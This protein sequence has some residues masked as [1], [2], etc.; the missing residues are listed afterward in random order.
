MASSLIGQLRILLG[1]ETASLEAGAAKAKAELRG[2]AESAEFVKHTLERIG[3][4]FAAAE[5]YEF[6]KGALEYAASL[7]TT[8]N[9]VGVTVEQLQVMRKAAREYGVE[10]AVM[11]TGLAKLNITLGKAKGGAAGAVKAFAGLGIKPEQLAS[12]HQAGDALPAVE[13]GL[14][15]VGDKATQGAAAWG[16]IGKGAAAALPVFTM[17]KE[18][19]DELTAAAVE[20][21][22]ITTDQAHRAHEAEVAVGELAVALKSRLAIAIADNVEE[23][24]GFITELEHMLGKIGQMMDML[25]S[26]RFKAS[27]AQISFNDL[28]D[29]ARAGM[30]WMGM[31]GG[32]DPGEYQGRHQGNQAQFAEMDASELRAYQRRH[33]PALFNGG[34]KEPTAPPPNHLD[35]SHHKKPKKHADHTEQREKEAERIK[36]DLDK[37]ELDG[38]KQLLE[39]QK[40]LAASTEDRDAIQLQ[41]LQ[42][43]HD[44]KALEIAHKLK[45][46]ELDRTVSPVQ[47]KAAELEAKSANA[48]NDR[49]LILNKANLGLQQ[50]LEQEREAEAYDQ[51]ILKSHT[52]RLKLEEDLV[53]TTAERRTIEL[54]LLRLAY[55]Q[56]ARQLKAII[57][58]TYVY[59]DDNGKSQTIYTHSAAERDQARVELYG[60]H[61][62][63]NNTARS[64]A[65]NYELERQKVLRS[66][67]GPLEQ[68][69][70]SIPDTAKRMN[71][72]L[73]E[74]AA[75]G[76]K[77]M[78]DGLAEASASWI[79]LGGTAG[80]ILRQIY[81]DIMKILIMKFIEK[82][83]INAL[84]GLFGGAGGG[85]L[86]SFAN[87][88]DDAAF[89]PGF[90]T[91]G[92][93]IIGG[94]GGVDRNLLS[95][96]GSPVARVNQGERLDIV[97][98]NDRGEGGGATIYN[99]MRGAVLTQDLYDH[100]NRVGV[101][102]AMTGGAL[103]Q[104][105]AVTTL[106]RRAARML[107]TGRR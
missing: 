73:E 31:A 27:K 53:K 71:E 47:K 4:G 21:G 52:D 65:Q 101:Q 7:S 13:E 66:T 50:R 95:I 15:N 89:L 43:D 63:G 74:V 3:I 56:R 90:A 17:G 93:L 79:K 54:E 45:M 20:H 91:G 59:T 48:L 61:G 35:L 98:A 40:S 22:L 97:P 26:L 88:Q 83:A 29:R 32:I 62:D 9:R 85:S 78:T 37:E 5:L 46:V 96:N 36:Y 19:L 106:S 11:E 38:K 94:M 42:I 77:S 8:A 1:L 102:A 25:D 72:A 100:A 55:E 84:Q 2:V 57:N 67:M 41:V 51:T 39:A 80:N 81:Q 105:G 6:A 28:T 92:S 14:K 23:I 104:A 68:L 10:Q 76:L 44:L 69:Q 18:A 12:F 49:L 70:D 75:N 107:P 99:D 34:P 58:D 103:G 87:M 33:F 60:Y 30:W 24:T 82:P 16:L 86:G 64:L